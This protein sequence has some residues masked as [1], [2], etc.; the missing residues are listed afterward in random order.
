MKYSLISSLSSN[1]F[2]S[3]FIVSF[4]YKDSALLF[5]LFSKN[6]FEKILL[7]VSKEYI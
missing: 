4:L 1:S 2:V 5:I 6:F 3:T 7:R